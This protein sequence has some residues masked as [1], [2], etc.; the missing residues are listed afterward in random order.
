MMHWGWTVTG[1]VLGGDWLRRSLSTVLGFSKMANLT[2]PEWDPPV[3]TVET[4]HAASLPVFGST[5]PRLAIVVPACNEGASVEQCL[6]SL[7]ELDYPNY[8]ICAIDDRSTDD[9][10]AIMDRLARE[11]TEKLDVLHITVLPS[12]WLGKTHAMWRGAAQT[13]SEWILFTDGDIFFRADALIRAIHYAEIKDCDHL[14]IM[15]TMIMK[16]FGERMMLSF[17]GFCGSLM[18]RLHKVQDPKTKDCIGAGAFN[19]IRRSAYDAIGT[20]E[21]LRMEVIEDVKLGEAVKRRGFSQHCVWGPELVRVRWAEGVF[22]VVNNMRK[23]LF[24]LLDFSWPLAAVA[25]VGAAIYHLGPWIGLVFAPGLA[26]IG[27]AVAVFAIALLYLRLSG[28]FKFSPFYVFTQPIATMMFLYALMLS[29]WSSFRH[30][31][32]VWRGTTYSLAEIRAMTAVARKEQEQR[33]VLAKVIS[34]PSHNA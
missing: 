7:L 13:Q 23:N 4:Q 17:F 6:D 24:S 29:A 18:I 34:D 20:F 1:A 31:G 12:G 33:R 5:H 32:V 26:K 16:G 27:F 30:G 25:G 8:K 10:G 15:P 14:V 2:R 21:S 3:K 28:M 9:T 11:H 22:G 19:L